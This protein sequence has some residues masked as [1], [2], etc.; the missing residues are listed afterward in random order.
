MEFLLGQIILFA[1]NF[2]IRSLAYC[3]GQLLPISQNTALFS[4]LGTTYGGDGR[5]TFALPDLRG[6]V[7]VH[8]GGG[9]SG[10]GLT[11]RALG[12]RGGLERVTLQQSEM[13]THNHVATTNTSI[14]VNTQPGDESSPNGLHIAG[15]NQAF[16]ED[17]TG[18][19]AGPSSSTTIQNTGGNQ[20]HINMQPYL[21]LN[22]EIALYGIF[23]SRN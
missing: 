19:L 6:R 21:A 8:S 16:S 11:P 18:T 3:N 17:A 12:S 4:I 23:P 7:V 10:P 15:Q 2:P 9:S 13:P 22:Y 1:G 20:S 5:T 14:A